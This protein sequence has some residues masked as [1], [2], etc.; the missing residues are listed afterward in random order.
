MCE[1]TSRRF[2]QWH[3]TIFCVENF[4]EVTYRFFV[5]LAYWN[6]GTFVAQFVTIRVSEFSR[7]VAR[8]TYATSGHVWAWIPKRE[9]ERRGGERKREPIN[10]SSLQIG[11]CKRILRACAGISLYSVSMLPLQLLL[12]RL[13]LYLKVVLNF[14]LHRKRII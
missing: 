13:L 7:S 1:L 6:F 14:R 9:T 5:F 11:W 10:R 2:Y 3:K 12:T 8:R 4:S